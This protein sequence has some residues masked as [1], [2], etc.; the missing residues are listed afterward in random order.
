[1]AAHGADTFA[2]PAKIA[3]HHQEIGDLLHVCRTMTVLR[4]P[5]AVTNDD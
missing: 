2:R 4:E 5:H 3:A 1:M